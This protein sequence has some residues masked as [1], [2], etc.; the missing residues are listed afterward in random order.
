VTV[1]VDIV[2]PNVLEAVEF[3]TADLSSP[4]ARVKGGLRTGS[5]TGGT[6]C[7]SICCP[8]ARY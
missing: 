4:F 5:K 8:Q 3:L 1:D 2:V 7:R 6:V